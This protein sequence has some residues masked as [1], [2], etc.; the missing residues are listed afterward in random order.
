MNNDMH[1]NWK[2]MPFMIN[3]NLPWDNERLFNYFEIN[4][5]EKEEIYNIMKPY[6]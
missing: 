3:Y 1:V 6:I 4:K 2:A 5:E